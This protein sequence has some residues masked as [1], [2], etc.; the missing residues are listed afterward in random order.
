MKISLGANVE[1]QFWLL[2]WCLLLQRSIDEWR[3][4]HLFCWDL[5]AIYTLPDQHF[6]TC[7][8]VTMGCRPD[9]NLEENNSFSDNQVCYC[10]KIYYNYNLFGDLEF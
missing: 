10:D 9:L 2:K 4:S 1:Y 7:K 6:H 3:A 8:S 5:F